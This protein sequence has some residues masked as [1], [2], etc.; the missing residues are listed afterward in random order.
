MELSQESLIMAQGKKVKLQVVVIEMVDHLLE[1]SQAG[2][3]RLLLV[4]SCHQLANMF[5]KALPP[6]SFTSNVSK[7]ELVDLYTPTA[8]GGLTENGPKPLEEAHDNLA[9][10]NPVDTSNCK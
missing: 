9:H 7:L 8:C 3:M 2:L 6:R 4:P 5:T 10:I 1:K